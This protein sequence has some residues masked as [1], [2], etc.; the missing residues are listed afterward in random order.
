MAICRMLRQDTL[1]PSLYCT[2][3]S[4]IW[5][6]YSRLWMKLHCP[7]ERNPFFPK[8]SRM[9]SWKRY[10]GD[11]THTKS[12]SLNK[13]KA[14]TKFCKG[15]RVLYP[16]LVAS[17]RMWICSGVCLNIRAVSIA[18]V[19]WKDWISSQS[20]EAK[21]WVSFHWCPSFGLCWWDHCLG[22]WRH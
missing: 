6:W 16:C 17:F 18:D 2:L 21:S 9:R 14:A 5:F 13:L 1:L 20:N 19:Q 15:N 10:N 11:N 12:S 22:L 3:I 4:C 8:I 7:F